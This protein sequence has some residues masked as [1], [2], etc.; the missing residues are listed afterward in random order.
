MS[1]NVRGSRSSKTRRSLVAGAA[2][3]ATSAAATLLFIP[4]SSAADGTGVYAAWTVADSKTEATGTFTGTVFPQIDAA[5]VD[6][7]LSV[8]RSATLTGTTP[9]GEEYGTSRGQ[10]YL[11]SAITAGKSQGTVTLN[12]E[13]APNPLTWSFAVG[14]VDAENISLSALDLD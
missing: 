3:V 14:D 4:L 12:F 13:S 6:G 1:T 2:A 5:A 11:T 8:A 9:F 7:S 10:T